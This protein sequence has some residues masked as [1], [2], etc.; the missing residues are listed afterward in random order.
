MGAAEI[1][2]I[3]RSFKKLSDGSIESYTEP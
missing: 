1:N 2:G 3:K